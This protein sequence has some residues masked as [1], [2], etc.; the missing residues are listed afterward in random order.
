VVAVG[1]I[2]GGHHLRLRRVGEALL[3]AVVAQD[4][5][6]LGDVEGAVA[7]GDAVR[8]VEPLVDDV[9]RLAVAVAIGLDQRV[10]P[11]RVLPRADE[12]GAAG[13]EGQRAGARQVGRVDRHRE[14][15]RQLQAAERQVVVRGGG[16]SSGRVGRGTGRRRGG[17]GAATESERGG[18]EKQGEAQK[19]VVRIARQRYKPRAGRRP[20]RAV[21]RDTTRF[22][23]DPC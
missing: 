10:D 14:A 13:R 16:R 17:L 22:S 15:L 23:W 9:H 3:K 5:R 2:A 12:E 11:A 6:Q 8:H 19:V 18:D 7:E 1:G 21:G 20:R 4:A